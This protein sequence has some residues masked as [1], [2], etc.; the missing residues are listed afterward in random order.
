MVSEPPPQPLPSTAHP[1]NALRGWR[2]FDLSQTFRST[3]FAVS[4]PFWKSEKQR[5]ISSRDG[6]TKGPYC[7]TG[8]PTGA[9]ARNKNL[10]VGASAGRGFRGA[11]TQ[12]ATLPQRRLQNPNGKWFTDNEIP[13]W[14]GPGADPA[15]SE[16]DWDASESAYPANC[17]SC[18]LRAPRTRR[19]RSR[20]GSPACRR[21]LGSRGPGATRCRGLRRSNILRLSDLQ[22][23]Q[24]HR[25]SFK[26]FDTQ[27][28]KIIATK[29]CR[30][31]IHLHATAMRASGARTRPLAREAPCRTAPPHLRCHG[32]RPHAIGRISH[33]TDG[34]ESL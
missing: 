5:W 27:Y 16:K 31:R 4:A 34:R 6:I 20:P 18:A 10:R 33:S 23:L 11:A 28:Q 30:F 7:T 13:N 12:R 21:R 1:C 22:I 19:Q 2:D 24:N 26:S 25:H 9:P 14:P 8:S 15:S 3:G 32:E 29:F 17:T